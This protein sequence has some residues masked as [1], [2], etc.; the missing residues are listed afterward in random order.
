M[1]DA[2]WQAA[3]ERHARLQKD[4][5]SAS[6]FVEA[7]V[8]H[9][10]LSDGVA[11][12][13]IF[14]CTHGTIEWRR[15]AAR[16]FAGLAGFATAADSLDIHDTI[17]CMIAA[18]SRG[19]ADAGPYLEAMLRLLKE[20][21][22]PVDDALALFFDEDPLVDFL[23]G[24]SRYEG[25]ALLIEYVAL[26]YA[27]RQQEARGL[28]RR[29]RECIANASATRPCGSDAACCAV[30]ILFRLPHAEQEIAELHVLAGIMISEFNFPREELCKVYTALFFEGET[31]GARAIPVVQ[32]LIT[33][34]DDP[35]VPDEERLFERCV[36][37]FPAAA[38]ATLIGI[39]C[40]AIRPYNGPD[41]NTRLRASKVA[42]LVRALPTR[43]EEILANCDK[44]VLQT[45][46]PLVREWQAINSTL[47]DRPALV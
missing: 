15:Q 42:L 37:A 38:L 29:L 36:R 20:D 3:L 39:I 10:S 12:S 22:L 5:M 1:G 32:K 9:A 43:R 7:L 2:R 30:A 23:V 26:V 47:F 40:G 24:H 11:H 34:I 27:L 6:Q 46:P 28:A 8:P 16:H 19:L 25:A 4:C 44:A 33:A 31:I 35:L 17:R 13:L 41:E 18:A 14:T 21:E 45:F